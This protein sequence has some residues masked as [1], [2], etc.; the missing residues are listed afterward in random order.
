MKRCIRKN[1]TATLYT[2]NKPIQYLAVNI[3]EAC[4]QQM[5]YNG[6][7]AVLS[8]QMKARRTFNILERKRNRM[9]T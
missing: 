6:K 5:L 1:V 8:S 7:V 3:Y 2:L 4:R 9:F